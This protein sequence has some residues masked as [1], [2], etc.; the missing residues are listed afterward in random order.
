MLNSFQHLLIER[1]LKQVQNDGLNR[2]NFKFFEDNSI[3]FL[4]QPLK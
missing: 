2:V 4:F 3:H 1:I